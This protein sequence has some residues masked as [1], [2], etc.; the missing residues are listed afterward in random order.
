MMLNLIVNNIENNQQ[1]IFLSGFI[2]FV[3]AFLWALQYSLIKH[4]GNLLSKSKSGWG[5]LQNRFDLQQKLVQFKNS[6]PK[7]Y[8]LLWQRL[9]IEHFYGLPLT[10][11]LLAIGYVLALFVGLVEDVVTTDS[12]VAIDY[13]FSQHMAILDQSPII[14]VFILI[15]SLGSTPI[16][17]LVILLTA[18]L[19]WLVGQRYL[20]IGLLI[21]TLG[22]TTFTYLSKL[23]FQRDRPLDILLFEQ[24]YSFPSG[25]ATIAIALYGFLAYLAI[26]FSTN[27]GKQVPIGI[28]TLFLCIMI[29][30]SRIVLNE[31]YLSDVLGGYLVGTLWLMVAISLTE[32]LTMKNKINWWIN[33][34]TFQIRMV[35]FSV[36]TVLIGTIIYAN[37]SQ[38]PLL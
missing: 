14:D 22:S 28:L 35:W 2:L 38:F 3:L 30:L 26:R 11:L 29:G 18:G 16:T 1:L 25:H 20:I 17:A 12:I 13:F 34:S 31:H 6:Y 8:H 32:W 15:T 23:L 27:F 24:T 36:I 21:T 33:W 5:A 4:T 37:T 19:C 10:T 7:L 9:N